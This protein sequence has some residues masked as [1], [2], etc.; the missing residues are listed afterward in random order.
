HPGDVA[1]GL[2]AALPRAL[3]QGGRSHGDGHDGRRGGA[4]RRRG[5]IAVIT[6]GKAVAEDLAPGLEKAF[7][8]VPAE[9]SG[10]VRAEG[11]LPAFLRGTY[12]LNGP[13]RF[14]R[15]GVRYRH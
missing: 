7:S 10:P 2:R 4:G 12:Y 9:R 11:T 13:A 1:V 5:R 8:F 6:E 15:G 3:P 14:E